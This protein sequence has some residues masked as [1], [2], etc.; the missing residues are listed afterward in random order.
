MTIDALLN[1]IVIM[2]PVQAETIFSKEEESEVDIA[3]FGLNS[4]VLLDPEIAIDSL[5]SIGGEERKKK[6]LICKT[7]AFF[8]N[9]KAQNSGQIKEPK[10]Y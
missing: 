4:V 10:A 5:I 2:A 3:S 1:D 6:N 8:V 9:N 7:A